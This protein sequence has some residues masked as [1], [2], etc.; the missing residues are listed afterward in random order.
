MPDEEVAEAF[1]RTFSRHDDP[2]TLDDAALEK[3][4][5]EFQQKLVCPSGHSNSTVTNFG[6][7]DTQIMCLE[8]GCALVWDLDGNIV[9][10]EEDE[11]ADL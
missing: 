3:R 2:R 6:G 8:R 7:G 4:W 11:E 9:K 10:E 1:L 5:H